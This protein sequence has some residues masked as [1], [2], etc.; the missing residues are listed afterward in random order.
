MFKN[1]FKVALRNLWKHRVFSMINIM[2]L[3]VGMTA[4]F[5]IYL[6]V[7]F[8]TNY[9]AFNT[10]ADRIYRIVTDIKTPSD[11]L[12]WSATSAPMAINMEKD[13]PEVESAVRIS[14]Q[15]FLVRKGNEKFQEKNSIMADSTLFKIFDFPLIYGDKNTA[16]KEP[17]SVVLSQTAA[18]KYFGNKNPVGQ[19]VILTGKN[20]NAT[21]TGVMKDIPENS[22]IKADMIVSMSSQKQIYGGTND[23][24]WANFY[25]N[26][27]L[28]LKPHTNYKK[29]EAKFPDFL[30]RHTGKELKEAQMSFTLFLEPLR[31]VYLY[32]TRDGSQSGNINNV[33]IF[34]VIALFILLIACINFINLTTARSAERAKEVGIRKVIGAARLQL[35]KQ[36]TGESVVISLIAF[37]I[38]V[39]LCALLLPSFNQLAGKQ[40]STAFF[41]HP[42]YIVSLFLISVAIGIIGG[43]YPALVLSSY[44]PVAVLKGRF[45]TGNKGVLLRKGLVIFQ[46]TISIIL[47]TGTL[48]V[49]NQLHYMRSRDLG[50]NKDQTMIIDTNDDKNKD[51]FKESLSSIQGVRSTAFSS[52]IPGGGVNTAYSKVENNNGEMQ[53]TNLDIYFVD[54]NF[55]NQYQMKLVAGRAFSPDYGGDTTHA[56]VINESASKLLGFASPQQA[57]GK[58]FD[59]WGRQGKII[60]VVKDFHYQALQQPIKALSMRIDSSDNYQFLSVKVAAKNLPST[61]KAIESKWNQIIPNR[62]FDYSFLDESFDKQYRAEDRFGELF[63]NFAILAIFISCLG[64]LGLASYSTLQRTKEISVRKVL[65]ASVSG[66]T[67]LLTK[68]FIRLVLIGLLIAS[69]IAWFIMNK[70]LQG[71]AY[72]TNIGWGTFAFAGIIAVLIAIITVSFQAIKA[73]VANP[74][75]SLRSE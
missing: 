54:F 60:G 63:F 32:S 13:F 34:S 46:F 19:T 29:L 68:D 24:S 33:Y 58:N 25:L 10:K 17:M 49:Y 26:S 14:G 42:M 62:P 5:L 39:I 44:K 65:G 22:Q 16:L 52:G 31:D 66:V 3:A 12:H 38:S 51:A 61:I 18:K 69:P 35:A 27:Y 67:T 20:L 9:D 74:V 72:R 4:C 43:F 57:I 37:I 23:S 75:K 53:T 1:Y 28:L 36:F 6:Y 8:E 21:V 48:I 70:W 47:I 56:M 40:I 7:H 15:S 2:G 64:L 30:D 45:L 59:Q 73:A 41:Y 55:I 50:F 11:V 71:F